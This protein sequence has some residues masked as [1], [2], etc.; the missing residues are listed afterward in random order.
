MERLKPPVFFLVVAFLLGWF[1]PKLWSGIEWT[2]WRL[3]LGGS[4]SGRTIRDYALRDFRMLIHQKEVDEGTVRPLA[5]VFAVGTRLAELPRLRLDLMRIKVE[6]EEHMFKAA[7]QNLTE[8]WRSGMPPPILGEY[9][10]MIKESAS[11]IRDVQQRLQGLCA[12]ANV[13]YLLGEL[14]E[15]NALAKRNWD[16]ARKQAAEDDYQ[17]MWMA[18]YA[19]FN[20]TLFLGEFEEAME[21]M[22]RH[23]SNHYAGWDPEKKKKTI[24]T[25]SNVLTLN[26]VLSIPRHLMLAAAFNGSPRLEKQ[27]WPSETM[28]EQLNPDERRSELKWVEC[29]YDEARRICDSEL[30]SLDFSHAY[31]GFFLTLLNQSQEHSAEKFGKD[32][33]KEA[34]NAFDRIGDDS[35]IVSRYAKW[36]FYGIYLLVNANSEEALSCLRK[37]AEY[38]AISGNKFADCIFMCCHAV[39][40]QRVERH[41]KP[42]VDYYLAESRRLA[43]AMGRTF[44]FDLCEA[45]ASEVSRLRGKTGRAERHDERSKNGR[46]GE[47]ILSIFRDR[48]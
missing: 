22:A 41:L 25:L 39:A 15:G 17:L 27:Y 33:C 45:A 6:K 9:M 4:T 29:W 47:R 2:L 13:M 42:E 12:V 5:A 34:E 18:S 11:G 28:F 26:P 20:S 30:I 14:K 23:W 43:R 19:Y 35:P 38:S 40:A 46:A 10:K 32:L 7:I 44:Y 16:Y 3:L 37:A 8:G 1:L 31:A 24:E 48:R 21:L 36:G